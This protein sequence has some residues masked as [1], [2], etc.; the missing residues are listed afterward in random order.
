[1]PSERTKS[2]E[3]KMITW[4]GQ[5]RFGSWNPGEFFT[6]L[7]ARLVKVG[8]ICSPDH[9][10]GVRKKGHPLTVCMGRIIG[11][12]NPFALEAEVTVMYSITCRTYESVF[13]QK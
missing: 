6:T 8:E 4:S 11:L 9:I 1:M 10:S 12:Q 2:T 13:E 5:T 3:S 7:I